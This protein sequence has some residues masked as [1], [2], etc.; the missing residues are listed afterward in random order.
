MVLIHG[1]LWVMGPLRS[2]T[3]TTPADKQTNLGISFDPE[4]N[5]QLKDAHIY[6]KSTVLCSTT[7]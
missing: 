3:A 4:S 7:C 1:N 2:P 5:Q 6:L